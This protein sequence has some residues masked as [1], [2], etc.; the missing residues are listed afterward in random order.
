[1]DEGI[2]VSVE[3]FRLAPDLDRIVNAA[4]SAGLLK[5]RAQTKVDFK[6]RDD[7]RGFYSASVAKQYS[8]VDPRILKTAPDHVFESMLTDGEFQFYLALSKLIDESTFGRAKDFYMP[9]LSDDSKQQ[10]YVKM[11]ERNVFSNNPTPG[12]LYDD[13]A[14][15]A[16]AKLA[17]LR[18]SLTEAKDLVDDANVLLLAVRKRELATARELTAGRTLEGPERSLLETYQGLNAV[19]SELSV[20]RKIA[21]LD[22]VT[23]KIILSKGQLSYFI[24]RGIEDIGFGKAYALVALHELYSAQEAETTV[25]SREGHL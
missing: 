15:A 20:Y 4:I 8:G 3:D 19:E 7:A 12:T 23:A 22:L 24:D 11:L 14:A 21:N 6:I 13:S 5:E 18:R 16:V 10:F 1:M 2:E 9:R 25:S 17:N